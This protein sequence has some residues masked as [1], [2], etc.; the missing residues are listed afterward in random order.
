MNTLQASLLNFLNN[1]SILITIALLTIA[2]YLSPLFI[3]GE[4]LHMVVY[5]NLDSNV[6][7]FKILAESG[8]IFADSM[9]IIPNMMNGLPRL[10]YGNEFNLILW[11][12]YFLEPFHAYMLNEIIMH[13]F[14]FFS[15][16]MLLSHY[17]IDKKTN[18]YYLII[19]TVSLL[20]ALLPFWPS[21]GLSIVAQPLVLYAFLNIYY[22]TDTKYDWLILILIPFYSSFVFS[23][24]FF[25][26]FVG[27]FFIYHT[28]NSKQI[29]WKFFF[30][31]FLMISVFLLINYRLVY[32]MLFDTGFISHRTTFNL[33]VSNFYKCFKES[34]LIFLNGQA[35]NFNMHFQYI[36]PV[37]LLGLFVSLK[38]EKFTTVPSIIILITFSMFFILDLW[39][40][41]LTQKNSLPVLLLFGLVIWIYNKENKIFPFLFILQILISFFTGFYFYEGLNPLIDT[42]PIFHSFHF[43]RFMLL[44]TLIWYILLALALQVLLQ[45]V[46]FSI[47]VLIALIAM[48]TMLNFPYKSFDRKHMIPMSYK[49]YY[50]KDLYKEIEDF[51]GKPKESYRIVNIGIEPAVSLYNGFYTIDGY[52]ANYP[53]AY[54]YQFRKIMEEYLD[55]LKKH[56]GDSYVFDNWGSKAYIVSN[57]YSTF[58]YKKGIT[59]KNPSINTHQ[60]HHLGADY[61]FSAYRIEGYKKLNLKFLKRF[62]SEN[63]YW[64]VYLY[65]VDLD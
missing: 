14:A 62:E 47:V 3:Y 4:S 33:H 59:L 9:D 64:P 20:F 39:G 44:Q 55:S 18:Y 23:F 36:L 22:R 32:N 28:L 57:Q 35:H 31:L 12:Y 6:V 40:D 65:Q 56:Q 52:S 42:F 21:G 53:L 58:N 34:H 19:T 38:K 24:F 37:I 54:K 1:K 41:L 63:S 43:S 2:I 61:I 26:F 45:N 11:F 16:Y 49:E 46:K 17:I 13:F 10:S 60:I 7:W 48:Q 8:K 50:A 5:D 30:A 51:I 29:H 25:L 15:M 27:L